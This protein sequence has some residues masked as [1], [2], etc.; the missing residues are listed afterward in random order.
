[1]V[2]VADVWNDAEVAVQVNR[3]HVVRFDLYQ[4]RNLIASDSNGLCDP[5][6]VIKFNVIISTIDNLY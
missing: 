4:C 3:P 5:Y 6:L 1:M 2:Q